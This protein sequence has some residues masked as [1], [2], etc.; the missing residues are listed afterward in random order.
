MESMFRFGVDYYPEQWPAERWPEDAR[1]MSEAGINVV[2]LAEFAWSFLEPEP[3]CFEFDWLDRAIE[4]LYE[5]GIQVVLGTPTASAPPW[6]MAMMPEAYKVNEHGHRRTYGN[7][8]EFCPSHA[9]YRQRGH[10]IVTA[11]ANHYADHP[12]VVGWQIDNELNGR[13]YCSKCEAGFQNWLQAR[14]GALETLNSAWG[15]AFWS[16]VYTEWPQIP[17]PMETGGVPNPGL[18]LDFRRFMSDTFTQFQQE[19]MDILRQACPKHFITHNFMGFGFDQ[20]NY[21]DLA[22]PLDFVSWDNYPRTGWHLVNEVDP[23]YIALGHDMTRGFKGKPFWVMEQQSGSGGWQ[24][25]GMTPRPGEMRLWTYQA[26]AH[27][28]DAV[29]YFRWRT[30]RFGTEQYWHGVLYHHGQ[31]GRRYDELK[32]IGSELKRV[33]SE[34]A[35][36]ENRNQVAMILSYD[37]RWAFQGQPNHADFKYASLFTSYYKALHVRNIGVDIVPPDA[38][39]SRYRLVIAPAVYVLAQETADR[40]RGF[41]QNGGTLIATAR[42]GVKDEANAVVN[43]YLPGLL[44]EVCGVEVVDYDVRPAE[45]SVPLE[46]KLPD[47]ASETAHARLWFDVLRPVSA[48]AVATYQSEYFSGSPAITL[49][50]FG[51]GQAIYAGTLGDDALHDTLVSW[52]LESANIRSVLSSPIGVEV[53]ERWQENRQLLFLLNHSNESKEMPLAQSYTDLISGAFIKEHVKL[54]PLGVV[55]LAEQSEGQV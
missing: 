44:A 53:V 20:I 3:G 10:L 28:A 43:S 30:A 8:C 46:L 9:G 32:L 11:M 15:T 40:L 42:T 1:L 5:R 25:V 36:A 45:M 17:V 27:G 49:N 26:I 33:G 19:Q 21:Y 16:H 29:V 23:S 47:G 18:D 2:R 14:Y 50:R 31:P 54:P 55:V 22:K 41:V 39:L 4:I 6:L 48:Q 12:A 24:T 37:T 38:D 51:A 7:R 35:G 34:F 13:C 52:A